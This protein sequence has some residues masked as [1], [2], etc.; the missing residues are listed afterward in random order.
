MIQN[1]IAIDGP[2]G[3]GKSSVTKRVAASFGFLHIDTGALFRLVGLLLY[4]K[5]SVL[6]LQSDQNKRADLLQWL[7]PDLINYENN[8][9]LILRY[10]GID[11]SEKIRQ[12][13][14][15]KLAS[16][17]S[18]I[19]I[20]RTMIEEIQRKIVEKHSDYCVIEGRDI[21][22]VVFPNAK[23][24]IFLTASSSVRAQRRLNE[25]LLKG[26]STDLSFEQI[27]K[28]IENRDLVDMSRKHSPLKQA[29]DAFM[30]D[31]SEMNEDQVV[32]YLVNLI[33]SKI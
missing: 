31:T 22:T 21:G 23:V 11:Y 10:D 15:S 26:Q 29:A 20:I 17:Y 13:Y 30:V 2:A 7:N 6:E 16:D 33:K 9:T 3:S 4:P 18:Q 24:K 12:H 1:I 25:L 14:V 28:D 5:Y 32:N 27:K 19:P 8:T